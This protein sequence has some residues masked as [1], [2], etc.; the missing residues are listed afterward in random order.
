MIILK[1]VALI[2]ASIALVVEIA[3]LLGCV[4][5]MTYKLYKDIKKERREK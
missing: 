2:L 5:M 4:V 1:T 3:A